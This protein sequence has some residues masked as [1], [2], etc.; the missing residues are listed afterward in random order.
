MASVTTKKNWRRTRADGINPPVFLVMDLPYDACTRVDPD[1]VAN[2]TSGQNRR[3]IR[4]YMSF[5]AASP[6]LHLAFYF[7]RMPLIMQQL[8]RYLVSGKVNNRPP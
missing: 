5:N 1:M 2:I 6:L 8:V 7:A 4:R 3:E